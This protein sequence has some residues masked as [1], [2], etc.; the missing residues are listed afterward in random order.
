MRDIYSHALGK[1][2]LF[3]SQSVNLWQG[4]LFYVPPPPALITWTLRKLL[5]GGT[6]AILIAPYWPRQS[7]FATLYLMIKHRT[8]TFPQAPCHLNNE[9]IYQ[10]QS[11]QP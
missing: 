5:L 1:D 11:L 4:I 3:S 7:W 8:H 6:M 10:S 2:S 9:E